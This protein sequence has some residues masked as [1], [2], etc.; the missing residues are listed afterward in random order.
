MPNKDQRKD[1]CNKRNQINIRGVP[2]MILKYIVLAFNK[3]ELFETLA[4]FS[5]CLQGLRSIGFT[6]NENLWQHAYVGEI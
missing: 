6:I 3:S 4:Y 2:E 1:M 5:T